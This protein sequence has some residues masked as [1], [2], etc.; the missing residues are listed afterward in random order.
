MHSVYIADK[1]KASSTDREVGCGGGGVWREWMTDEK[2]KKMG[3]GAGRRHDEE[4][5]QDGR[6]GRREARWEI[7]FKILIWGRKV[8][9]PKIHSHHPNGNI[10]PW[11]SSDTHTNTHTHVNRL[12]FQIRAQI[13]LEMVLPGTESW[14]KLEHLILSPISRRACSTFL[15]VNLIHPNT[16]TCVCKYV[17]VC[18]CV[19]QERVTV[20]EREREKTTLLLFPSPAFTK[21]AYTDHS[22]YK[23]LHT[24]TH[25]H[26]LTHIH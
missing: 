25:T 26:T 8:S 21:A 12:C 9:A 23:P 22:T 16:V 13:H 3:E 6:K 18:V 20:R 17:C 4:F 5:N 1:I 11:S 7:A 10:K 2:R 24:H 15:H 19:N 14:Q